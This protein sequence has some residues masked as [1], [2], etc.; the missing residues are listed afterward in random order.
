M[1]SKFMLRACLSADDM[2]LGKSLTVISLIASNR[3][4]VAP[5]VPFTGVINGV[6]G[7]ITASIPDR[8][9][10]PQAAS[11]SA[12]HAKKDRLV[13]RARGMGLTYG[14]LGKRRHQRVDSDDDVQIIDPPSPPSSKKSEVRSGSESDVHICHKHVQRAAANPF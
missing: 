2:G 10:P 1:K 14:V 3:S 7:G 12:G 8:D 4:G 6:G 9:V 13:R 11:A 5:P